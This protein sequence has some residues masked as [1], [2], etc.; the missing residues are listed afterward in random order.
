MKKLKNIV[1][2]GENDVLDKLIQINNKKSIKSEIITS[3]DQSKLFNKNI[4]YKVYKKLDN[5]FKKYIKNKYNIEETLFISIRS[6]WIF[7]KDLINNFFKGN[8]INY[9][10]TRL[11]LD[12]G[13]GGFS[14]QIMRGD[15]IN[16]QLFHMIDDKIDNGPIILTEKYI[17]PNS[18]KFPKDYLSFCLSKLPIFYETLLNKIIKKEKLVIQHQQKYLSRYCP[19]LNTKLNGWIDWNIES[20]E[21]SRFI[22]AF[23]DPY[24]GASTMINDEK[25]TIKKAYLHSGDSSNHPFMAGMVSRHDTN[26]IVVSTKDKHMLLIREVLNKNNKNILSKIKVGDRFYTP[27]N[28]LDQAKKIRVKVTPLGTIK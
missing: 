3:P 10:P 7:S 18:C 11:P 20:L 21:L 17:F 14:W 1:F 6:R 22:D 2:I 13:A 28:K 15:K 16:N 9:H 27:H 25:V 4:K 8:L 12:S 5:K 26:W 19:R 24:I 23:D